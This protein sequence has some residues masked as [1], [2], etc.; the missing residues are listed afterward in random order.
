MGFLCHS[1]RDGLAAPPV[2]YVF[3]GFNVRVPQTSLSSS[4]FEM[5]V[6][7]TCNSHRSP[8]V[9]TV[10]RL[11]RTASEDG[12]NEHSRGFPNLNEVNSLPYG[13]V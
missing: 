8:P 9:P 1:Y 12:I 6:T 3:S 2:S 11:C 7:T 5:L 4:F 13:M 10:S